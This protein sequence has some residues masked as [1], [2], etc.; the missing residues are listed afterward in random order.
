MRKRIWS[1]LIVIS[2]IIISCNNKVD[3]EYISMV[4][5]PA[6]AND[7]VIYE[8][9]TRQYTDEGTFKAFS[10]HLPRLKELG[11]EILWFMPIH[12]I[13]VIDRKGTLG[14]Y[15]SVMDYKSIN[16]EFG[17]LDDFRNLVEEAHGLGMKV[18]IDWVANH[19]SR[20]GVWLKN[21]SEW[22]VIDSI[23]KK[24]VAPFD[25]TDVAKLDFSNDSLR[26]A[27]IDAMKYW[28]EEANIDGFRCDV[29]GEVPVD[30]WI[31]AVQ[32]LKKIQPE[33]F[34]LA[35]AELPVLQ[36]NA[37]N[38][39]YGWRF[40]HIMNGIAAGKFNTDSIRNYYSKEVTKF[41]KNTIPMNFTS[42]HDENSWNGTEFERLKEHTE[43]MA[44]L[45]FLLP[46]MP[47]IYNGQ[48]VG[49]NKRLQFF[50]KDIID[51]NGNY[52]F[53]DLYKKLI[54][55]RKSVPAIYAFNFDGFSE[56]KTNDSTNVFAFLR[57]SE[58]SKLVGLFNFSSI[59][60]KIK[61]QKYKDE[62]GYINFKSGTLAQIPETIIIEPFGYKIF[63]K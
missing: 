5:H 34:M 28:L 54:Q 4:E 10:N 21:N 59:E 23:T 63:Y 32:E 50:E 24:P 12:K 13:G 1:S 41:P 16:P 35:E 20:D 56:I 58:E 14:S 57:E 33:L 25:W 22:Y 47:L 51:W 48:E 43:Q 8:V 6:W 2:F 46:G 31:M 60:V 30:F 19:T 26:F 61:L 29:A 27:M 52:Y 3:N 55:L 44:V 36:E 40:H 37:F 7:A 62:D 39:Y 38:M 53:T 11:V 45:S 49:F 17:T 15:Y 9:N 18:I 42:N